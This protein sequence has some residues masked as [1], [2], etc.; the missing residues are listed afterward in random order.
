MTDQADRLQAVAKARLAA[1]R[2]YPDDYPM[3]AN[4]FESDIFIAMSDADAAWREKQRIK[5]NCK[6]DWNDEF[7]I[8]EPL[9]ALLVTPP[10]S[11]PEGDVERVA[12][13][14]SEADR[15][16]RPNPQLY[17]R[18]AQ[19][20]T[21]ARAAFVAGAEYFVGE[22]AALSPTPQPARDLVAKQAEDEGLW[23]QAKTAPEAYLQQELRKLHAAVEGQSAPAAK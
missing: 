18:D 21:V 12:R 1:I 8:T 6:P 2:K 5:A 9:H 3:D 16:Y 10:P 17:G 11:A 23:F 4:E 13:A 14:R 15:R 20:V 19:A 22:I 7:N